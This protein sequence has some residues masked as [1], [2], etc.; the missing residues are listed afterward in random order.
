MGE[1]RFWKK[2]PRSRAEG[3]T[4][5][6]QGRLPNECEES[7]ASASAELL[8]RKVEP[9]IKIAI[10][11]ALLGIVLVSFALGR[12]PISPVELISTLG[13]LANNA[14]A[15]FAAHF[16]VAIPHVEVNQQM[17]TALMNIRLPRILVV[18]LVG[19]A[20]AVAG[21]SYQ[22]MFKNPLVSP[23]IL[24]AS[25]G[26]SFG[27]CL[28]LLFDM[29][30]SMVQLFAFIGAMVAVGG[31]VWMNK[32]V[33][34]YD[35][36]LGLVL[37]GM[38]VTTLFQSFTSLVKFMAD[39]NDKLPAITFWLMGSFSRINQT[40]LAVIVA[41][42][43]AGFVLL[44]LERWKLNV[45]SFGEE[46]ARSLGVNTG[47]VRL[48]VIF[49][50]TLIV[51]CSVAVAGIVGWVG[52]VIPHLARSIVGPNYK[53]L[54]PTSMFIGAGYLLIVDDLCRLMASTEI[55][56]GILTAII[57][58]PFFIFIFRHNIKGW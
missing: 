30:N 15:N 44:M 31:A 20:L 38:L 23:D 42:M 28:A 17:A 11:I 37:G 14:L 24:G 12:Y 22:G 56:I 49:A 53:V 26:A 35:A 7:E 41:P 47:R 10:G 34:K 4:D 51:A 1:I 25:A 55:P 40:D 27:A 16:G 13:A 48:I 58:V 50:S 19:A 57:G 39:A 43:L 5:A 32:M 52:L 36:L 33:N 6:E 21:A 8:D 18:M 29:S 3:D 2:P 9:W 46:E 45:L 54:L